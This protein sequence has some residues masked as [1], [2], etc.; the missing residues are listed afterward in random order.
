MEL[1]AGGPGDVIHPLR[2]L[3]EAGKRWVK[4]SFIFVPIN[5]THKF[6]TQLSTALSQRRINR[7]HNRIPQIDD[8]KRCL[9]V[10]TAIRNLAFH[11]DQIEILHDMVS[12]NHAL[13][14][15]VNAKHT[16]FKVHLLAISFDLY[17]YI[18]TLNYDIMNI[19]HEP[20]R[21]FQF[22]SVQPNRQHFFAMLL[23]K[24]VIDTCVSLVEDI[25]TELR[26]VRFFR[27]AAMAKDI[28]YFQLT[29]LAYDELYS[30]FMLQ[31]RILLC[32]YS[33]LGVSILRQDIIA[34]APSYTCELCRVDLPQQERQIGALS[35]CLH[36]FCVVCMDHYRGNL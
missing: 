20:P 5:A 25:L 34:S 19:R 29:M 17:G 13:R 23:V 7:D 24:D 12:V 18:T 27:T 30:K 15:L 3:Y 21:R 10:R 8:F 1:F 36:L 9:S 22:T 16:A 11:E 33:F 2:F 35:N 14:N 32:R 28:S 26:I 4:N 31:N 6:I